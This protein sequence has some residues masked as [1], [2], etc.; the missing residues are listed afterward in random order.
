M[1]IS[2]PLS[3]LSLWKPFNTFDILSFV[4]W[5]LLWT[6]IPY[7]SSHTLITRGIWSTPAALKASKKRPSLVLAFPIVPH[8]TSSPLFE[9]IKEN[10]DDE[11]LSISSST[12]N[13]Q[14]K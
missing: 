5:Y 11:E 6:D 7:S 14:M 1:I 4:V 8:A 2:Y 10:M 9:N 13:Y 3:C 12:P